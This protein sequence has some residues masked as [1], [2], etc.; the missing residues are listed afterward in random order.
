M[1]RVPSSLVILLSGVF[2]GVPSPLYA[3]A[4]RSQCECDHGTKGDREHVAEVANAAACFLSVNENGH[5]CSF[6]VAALEGS[7]A[8]SDFLLTLRDGVG[9]TPDH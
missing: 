3:E 6:D 4:T 2:G 5:W 9:R 7:V 1:W 8:Q